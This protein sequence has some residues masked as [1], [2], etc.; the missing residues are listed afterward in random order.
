MQ[1]REGAVA[2]SAHVEDGA[3][4][5]VPKGPGHA[6]HR[7]PVPEHRRER[8]LRLVQRHHIGLLLL[9]VIGVGAG[10]RMVHLDVLGFN[11]DETVYAGQAA[12]LAGNPVYTTYFPVFR[13]HP[14]LVQTML[15]LFYGHGEH[16]VVGRYVIA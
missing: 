10:L 8:S 1:R 15:S 3:R 9:L 11:S 12:A 14:M 16:D 4:A 13:A 6:A 2:M 7:P 5:L